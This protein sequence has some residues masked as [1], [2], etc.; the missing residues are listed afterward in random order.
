MMYAVSSIGMGIF[1]DRKNDWEG[2]VSYKDFTHGLE[3]KSHKPCEGGGL[4][5]PLWFNPDLS[6]SMNENNGCFCYSLKYSSD[7]S[8]ETQ[9]PQQILFK[10]KRSYLHFKQQSKRISFANVHN[11]N[12]RYSKDQKA[13]PFPPHSPAI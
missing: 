6:I 13:I 9:K 4:N 10:H 5:R 8:I 11:E 2:K 12:V 7:L 1:L 3:P